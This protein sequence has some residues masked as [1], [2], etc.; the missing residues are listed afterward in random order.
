MF[1]LFHV[2]SSLQR[3]TLPAPAVCTKRVWGRDRIVTQDN[4][5]CNLSWCLP[6]LLAS[7]PRAVSQLLARCARHTVQDLVSDWDFTSLQL[8]RRGNFRK[9]VS[10]TRSP[11]LGHVDDLASEDVSWLLS[12]HSAFHSQ[13][14]LAATLGIGKLGPQTMKLDLVV[15]I[16]IFLFS[17]W[18]CYFD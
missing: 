5:V 4:T 1:L 12:P 7:Q 16:W 8:A 10:Y 17:L 2:Y 9:C 15:P 6:C 14:L 13:P 18:G 3:G 11:P